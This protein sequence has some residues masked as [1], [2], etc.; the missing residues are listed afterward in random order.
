MISSPDFLR[1]PTYVSAERSATRH[2]V[3]G[4]PGRKMGKKITIDSATLVNKVIEVI[5]ASILFNLNLRQVDILIHP[6]SLIHGI[7]N[8]IDGS[9]HLVASKPDMK[10]PISFALSW[11]DRSFAEVKFIDFTS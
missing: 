8:F 11:P 10:V 4:R 7:V 2:Q 5:E 1:K 6:A 3:W 9:S